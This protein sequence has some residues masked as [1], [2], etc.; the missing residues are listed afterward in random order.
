MLFPKDRPAS[1]FVNA[2][3]VHSKLAQRTLV[4]AFNNGVSDSTLSVD[5]YSCF[6]SLEFHLQS[7]SRFKT[8]LQDASFGLIDRTLASWPLVG[9]VAGGGGEGHVHSGSVNDAVGVNH[10]L[11]PP[12]QT[13]QLL[14]ILTRQSL[15]YQF[16]ATFSVSCSIL[17]CALFGIYCFA[18]FLIFSI[19][20]LF[21]NRC[22]T[23]QCYFFPNHKSVLVWEKH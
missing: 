6:V 8:D 3:D 4:L 14:L 21:C 23:T 20:R 11:L 13:F 22:Q 16:Y 9:Q 10:W 17:N 2:V 19:D 5:W 18:E 12:L 15:K 7:P 1:S